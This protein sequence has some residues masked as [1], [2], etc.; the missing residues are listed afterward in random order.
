M[1]IT[2]Q[3]G[4][5]SHSGTYTPAEVYAG[6]LLVK[7]YEATVVGAIASTD[8]EGEIKAHGDNVIIRTVPDIVIRDYKI[9]QNLNYETP[10]PGKVE[11]PIDQAKYY[12]VKIN[13][14]QQKQADI[15][16]A[17]KWAE[18]GSNQMKIAIDRDCLLAMVGGAAA[19]NKGDAA[20]KLSGNINLGKAGAP[21]GINSGNVIE[22][23]VEFGQVLAEQDVPE[24]ELALV[25]PAWMATKLKTSDLKD[26]SMTGD[27]ESVLRNGRLG[28]IDNFTLYRSNCLPK[29]ADVVASKVCTY[30]YAVHK[31]AVAFATQLVENETLP[32][33]NDFG[34]L[35]RGLQ[36]YGRKVING[37]G[38][39]EGYFTPAANS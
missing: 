14:V 9:G 34:T 27:G 12:A 31:S 3:S 38:L 10:T 1:A 22:K 13:K 16:F 2:M 39:A 5:P 17:D 24:S 8:Y 36:V 29:V 32:N 26:A 28:R 18:D 19:E 37:V 30:V 7:F 35:M 33:P 11:L 25:I 6:K 20:G 21:V 23:I 15:S 4:V